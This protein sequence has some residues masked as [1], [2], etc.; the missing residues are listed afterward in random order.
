[1][2]RNFCKI[3]S[4]IGRLAENYSREAAPLQTAHCWDGSGS[5]L[6]A[7]R[8]EGNQ[9]QALIGGSS[10]EL[11]FPKGRKLGWGSYGRYLGTMKNL[12]LTLDFHNPWGRDTRKAM[13]PRD[14]RCW[15]CAPG[16]FAMWLF[17][18]PADH[19]PAA[20]RHP[21]NRNRLVGMCNLLHRTPS[22]Q[23]RG[24]TRREE[25][26]GSYP[27]LSPGLSFPNVSR[28]PRIT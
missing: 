20:C 5:E 28:P 11:C 13:V 19:L 1:M 6:R 27:F 21:I 15:I 10:K 23:F 8:R 16:T 2:L 18:W 24:R 14:G 22:P 12:Q 4:R 17:T 7:F 25:T 26:P 9:E 3:E